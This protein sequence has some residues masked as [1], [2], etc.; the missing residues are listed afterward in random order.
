MTFALRQTPPR[1]TSR[2]KEIRAPLGPVERLV[3][4]V[5]V[6]VVLRASCRLTVFG[7]VVCKPCGV[8][9]RHLPR[10]LGNLE[11][12]ITLRI[13]WTY[14]L[15]GSSMNCLGRHLRTSHAFVAL[16]LWTSGALPRHFV[17]GV[18]ALDSQEVSGSRQGPRRAVWS[19]LSVW[20]Q[21]DCFGSSYSRLAVYFGSMGE[22]R[23]VG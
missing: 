15:T 21:A 5:T 20:T 12:C 16:A 14:G 18:Q 1:Y 22:D 2:R 19:C 23:T 13:S 4:S 10:M 9:G 17:Q 11:P 6:P 8:L 7:C 3:F